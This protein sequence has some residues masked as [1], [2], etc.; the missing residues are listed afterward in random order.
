MARAVAHCCRGQR[1]RDRFSH[2]PAAA[3]VLQTRLIRM[4]LLRLVLRT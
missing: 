2:P 3:A 4:V 1:V